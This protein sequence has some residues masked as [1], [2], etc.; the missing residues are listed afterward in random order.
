MW[1]RMKWHKGFMLG[2]LVFGVDSRVF[3][4]KVVRMS[5]TIDHGLRQR[6]L[7]VGRRSVPLSLIT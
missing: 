1:I 7:S 4:G 3:Q 5:R 6:N 2:S